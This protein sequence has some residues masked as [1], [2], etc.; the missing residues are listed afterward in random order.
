M[1]VTN[2]S[3]QSNPLEDSLVFLPSFQMASFLTGFK[4]ADAW[5]LR[6]DGMIVGRARDRSYKE[7]ARDGVPIDILV[8]SSLEPTMPT[9][10]PALEREKATAP[11]W[12]D[13]ETAWQDKIDPD[14]WDWAEA[15]AAEGAM[16]GGRF[17]AAD[18]VH[19]DA[20]AEFLD[21]PAD[22]YDD[23]T[24]VGR[25]RGKRIHKKHS[26]VPKHGPKSTKLRTLAAAAVPAE[27][28]GDSL[29]PTSTARPETCG[30]CATT[31]DASVYSDAE[32]MDVSPCQHCTREFAAAVTTRHDRIHAQNE[33]N[34]ELA[35]EMWML[36]YSHYY[37]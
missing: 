15:V 7:V 23:Y 24:V 10:S 28:I 36:H 22:P 2:T 21:V 8:S 20:Y 27:S 30:M 17:T 25:G 13:H 33:Y 26:V 3:A 16:Y 5:A 11:W 1:W 18:V 14:I 9:P 31:Q 19:P 37:D 4:D 32:I 6:S 35:H 12:G 29:P 34:E